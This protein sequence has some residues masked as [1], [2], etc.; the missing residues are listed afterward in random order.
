MRARLL[1]SGLKE[2]SWL[3]ENGGR[4]ARAQPCDKMEGRMSFLRAHGGRRRAI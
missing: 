4:D 3:E 1:D 2:V